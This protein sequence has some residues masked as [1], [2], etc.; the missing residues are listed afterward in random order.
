MGL[1]GVG[2][3]NFLAKTLRPAVHIKLTEAGATRQATEWAVLSVSA[4][5]PD[6]LSLV[7]LSL[8]LGT[9]YSY[10]GMGDG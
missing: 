8:L 6:A 3:W 7:F 5:M 1:H 9:Q 2:M 4:A 10:D